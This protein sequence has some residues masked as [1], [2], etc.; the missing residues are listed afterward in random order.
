M[1]PDVSDIAR[2]RSCLE[3]IRNLQSRRLEIGFQI[4]MFVKAARLEGCTWHEIGDVLGISPQGAW[5]TY[6]SGDVGKIKPK[7]VV[8][9]VEQDDKDVKHDTPGNVDK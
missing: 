6:H 2:R 4:R 7:V 8:I 1:N 9:G 5:E 3:T